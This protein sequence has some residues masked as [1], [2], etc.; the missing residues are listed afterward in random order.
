MAEEQTGFRSGYS[1]CDHLFTLNFIVSRYLHKSKRLYCAFVDYR[2]AFDTVDRISLWKKLISINVNG[3][4]LRVIRNLYAHAKSCVKNG[5]EISGFFSSRVGV[6][7]GENLS[8][9]L[10]ALYLND[11]VSH[12]S[13]DYD[14]LRDFSVD[15]D[16]YLSDNDI[17]VYYRMYALLYA[18]DTILLAET[19]E[20]L[21]SALDSMYTYC[22]DNKL[23]VNEK[24]TKI[25][26]FSRGKL[27]R[28]PSFYYNGEPLEIVS[29]FTYLGV[30][31]NYNNR[32]TVA[33]KDLH[34]KASRAMF[35]LLTK[36]RKL[37]LPLDVC[38]KLFDSL[39][40]PI[41]LY[42]VEIWGPYA[43]D[44]ADKLQLRFIKF[45]CQLKKSTPSVMVRG[46]TGS[47]PMA[48]DIKL[49]VLCFWFKLV[50]NGKDKIS[51]IIYEC[52]LKMF[53]LND[54]QCKWISYVKN[55]LDSLGMSYIFHSQANGISFNWFRLTVKRKLEDLYIQEW[56]EYMYTHE[57]CTNYRIY[58][59]QFGME[60][61][62]HSL[63]WHLALYMLK[64][65]TRNVKLPGIRFYYG[66]NNLTAKYNCPFCDADE[67]DEYHYVMS[68]P[69]F[70]ADRLKINDKL[71]FDKHVN[72]L[73]FA[74]I[75]NSKE[76]C[77][78]LANL[79]K[80]VRKSLSLMTL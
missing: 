30:T 21:Q 28:Y 47:F 19:P 45:L 59:T 48:C 10:F 56:H 69:H 14:G 62:I 32:F 72:T 17:Q 8:P 75:M 50:S 22:N 51:K 73:K 40:K 55:T 70:R 6:R 41:M 64:F 4:V 37:K 53:E 20:Q 7:Q 15:L 39:V 16:S 71:F 52:M 27:R 49:R 3:N 63:P 33:Q 29:S 44:I 24:K 60:T 76:M 54:F 35:G 34:D 11:L 9:L 5:G 79:C 46:D 77:F 58:K 65:R 42:G 13:A 68:C 80:A 38:L 57:S 78:N 74:V 2:K 12:L 23:C 61:Y 25:I 1:T 31:L 18:D 43:T 67:A 26:V 66:N 36:C